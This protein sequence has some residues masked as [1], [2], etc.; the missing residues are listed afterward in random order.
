MPASPQTNP[1]MTKDSLPAGTPSA[2]ISAWAGSP[3]LKAIARINPVK[4]TI[5]PTKSAP[6]MLRN[7]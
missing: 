1:H 2:K 7:T 3:K 4:F 6:P 5:L